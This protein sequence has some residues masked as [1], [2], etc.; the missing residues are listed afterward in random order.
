MLLYKAHVGVFRSSMFQA[1]VADELNSL[2]EN[3]SDS[4]FISWLLKP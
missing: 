4:L 2:L 1:T 3:K